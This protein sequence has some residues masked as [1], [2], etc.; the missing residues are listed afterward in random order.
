[1]M[2]GFGLAVGRIAVETSTNPTITF[3]SVF[4]SDVIIKMAQGS[5]LS[6]ETKYDEISE[7]NSS[8]PGDINGT[9]VTLQDVGSV[10][11]TLPHGRYISLH[12]W[13]S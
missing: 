1:M 7:Y 9:L 4:G 6:E 11:Y 5:L 8:W 10:N 2:G 3:T 12:H 13:S